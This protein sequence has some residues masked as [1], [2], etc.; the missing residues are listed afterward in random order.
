MCKCCAQN[1]QQIKN[2]LRLELQEHLEEILI[3]LLRHNE[4]LSA[5][6]EIQLKAIEAGNCPS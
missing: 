2:E 5:D 6:L 4:S 1:F 3:T